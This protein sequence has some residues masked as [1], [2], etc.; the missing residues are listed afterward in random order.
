MRW[1]YIAVATV[2]LTS[3]AQPPRYEWG[4]Y[5]DSLYQ[6]YKDPSKAGDYLEVLAKATKAG[7]A[8]GRT[9]PGVHA[10]YGYM[11]L[12][13]GRQADATAEFESEKRLWPESAVFMDRMITTE[14]AHRPPNTATS[15]VPGLT[16]K[17]GS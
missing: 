13:V 5:E 16:G 12:S 1:C 2:L 11:L 3:C 4:S 10:E 14:S 8:T 17:T 6:Y 15:A 9:A 7:D